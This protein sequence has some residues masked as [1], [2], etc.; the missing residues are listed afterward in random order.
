[1]STC[2]SKTAFASLVCWTIVMALLPGTLPGRLFA[3]TIA[4]EIDQ[5]KAELRQYRLTMPKIR[6][7]VAATL[8]FAKDVESDPALAKKLKDSTDP[9][10]RT[11]VEF[12]AR[13]DKEPRLSAAIKNAGLSSREYATLT[14]CYYPA[15]FAYAA[16]KQGA[17]KELPKDILP[18][19]L[20]LIE[21]NEAELNRLNQELQAHDTNK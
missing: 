1:M 21:A 2:T 14:L 6:Q 19:N 18:D 10:P 16:K 12:V 7:L 11:L 4:A 9:E 5:E 17:I 15:M 3:Q 20:A 8:A 13:I